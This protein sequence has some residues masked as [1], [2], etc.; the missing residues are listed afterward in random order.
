[1]KEKDERLHLKLSRLC[2]NHASA[3][4]AMVNEHSRATDDALTD[5]MTGL[6]KIEDDA[7][8]ELSLAGDDYRATKSD[9]EQTGANQAQW[10]YQKRINTIIMDAR[11]AAQAQRDTYMATCKA[12][13]NKLDDLNHQA[14]LD[15]L[16]GT[17]KLFQSLD[18]ASLDAATV[19]HAAQAIWSGWSTPRGA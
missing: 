6:A 16:V 19:A 15:L 5:C 17:Q 7:D 4:Q 12:A 9:A 13:G 14:R 10:E 18:V 8:A 11:D 1:M 3:I 2:D